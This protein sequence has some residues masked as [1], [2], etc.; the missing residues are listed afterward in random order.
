LD[1]DFLIKI[2]R[3]RSPQ[4]SVAVET[5]SPRL[6]RLIRKNLDL[7]KV[8]ATIEICNDLRIYTRG[9]FMLGFPTETEKELKATLDFAFKSK[10]HAALFFLVTPYKKTG[11][12]DLCFEKLKDKDFNLVDHDFFHSPIN[13]SDVPDNVLFRAQRWAS[14]R[15]ALSPGRIHRVLRDA[16]NRKTFWHG[17]KIRWELIRGSGS[18]LK[19][20]KGKIPRTDGI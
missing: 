11:L 14:V 5:A 9:F 18:G 4:I 20:K 1:R 2:S 13:C 15:F 3:F 6:Q 8:N 12:Y 10:L 17:I 16:P 7:K 19:K